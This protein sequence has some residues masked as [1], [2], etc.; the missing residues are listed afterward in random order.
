MINHQRI[1]MRWIDIIAFTYQSIILIEKLHDL[2]IWK[3]KI[4]IIKKYMSIGLYSTG[5]FKYI[6][7]SKYGNTYYRGVEK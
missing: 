4:I 5:V 1:D 3:K 6:H 7:W 2:L